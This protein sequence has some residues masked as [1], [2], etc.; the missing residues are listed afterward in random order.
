MATPRRVTH[1]FR[2]DRYAAIALA[3]AAALGLILA[4][5]VAGSGLIAL[6][7][8]YFGPASLGLDLS[9]GHWVTDGLLRAASELREDADIDTD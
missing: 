8:E 1:V 4:N 6:S 7:D 2:S 3:S 5:P 9:L